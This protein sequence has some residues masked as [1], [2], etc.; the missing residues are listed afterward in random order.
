MASPGKRARRAKARKRRRQSVTHAGSCKAPPIGLTAAVARRRRS[1]KR[2]AARSACGTGCEGRSVKGL[3]LFQGGVVQRSSYGQQPN[4]F[5]NLPVTIV[6]PMAFVTPFAVTNMTAGSYDARDAGVALTSYVQ[7]LYGRLMSKLA[8]RG[9]YYNPTPLASNVAI[10]TYLVSVLTAYSTVCTLR[11]V[12]NAA[13]LND[14]LGRMAQAVSSNYPLLLALTEGVDAMPAPAGLIKAVQETSGVFSSCGEDTMLVCGCLSSATGVQ[15]VPDL[16][17]AATVTSI[18]TYAQSLLTS[19]YTMGSD[20]QTIVSMMG[21]LFG[22]SSCHSRYLHTQVFCHPAF[23]AMWEYSALF[24]ANANFPFAIDNA[25]GGVGLTQV[26]IT[27]SCDRAKHVLEGTYLRPPVL[28]AS[29]VSPTATSYGLYEQL[30]TAANQASSGWYVTN[31]A[32]QTALDGVSLTP[33]LWWW[34]SIL[35]QDVSAGS[36]VGANQPF[37]Y[38]NR[39]MDENSTVV[40]V[41]HGD[42]VVSTIKFLDF[43][44]GL[45]SCSIG[46]PIVTALLNSPHPFVSQLPLPPYG[47]TTANIPGAPGGG[48]S[49]GVPWYEAFWDAGNAFA[50]SL[51]FRNIDPAGGLM[52]PQYPLIPPAPTGG[53]PQLRLPPARPLLLR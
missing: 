30:S 1:R 14:S 27:V 39:A 38:E 25:T 44:Y 16:T 26:P 51:G 43:I 7:N 17:V 41:N 20:L 46:H 28:A 40:W 47:S 6:R 9:D 50:E 42:M 4:H 13:S 12:L 2:K 3:R 52:G 34:N 15:A 8:A 36:P 29:R 31:G 33:G 32:L 35:F 11:G 23:T 37:S 45:T 53:P 22:H 21:S 24:S 5:S 48:G 19:L 10:N 49:G 18:L